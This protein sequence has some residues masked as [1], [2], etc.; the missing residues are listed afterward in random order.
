[1][2]PDPQ[3]ADSVKAMQRHGRPNVR[4]NR[5]VENFETAGRVEGGESFRVDPAAG[6][7]DRKRGEGIVEG[8][9]A[10]VVEIADPRMWKIRY[11]MSTA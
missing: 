10:V 8:D 4:D 7:Q 3:I 2:P 6:L 11:T 5:T 9:A 1:M